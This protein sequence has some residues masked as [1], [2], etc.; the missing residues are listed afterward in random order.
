MSGIASL[1]LSLYAI[2]QFHHHQASELGLRWF[3]FFTATN[4][5]QNS[6]SQGHSCCNRASIKARFCFFFNHST[7]IYHSR[8]FKT[9]CKIRPVRILFSPLPVFLG[10]DS[11]SS[12]NFR[13]RIICL[14]KWLGKGSRKTHNFPNYPF[15]NKIK[16]WKLYNFFLN[17]LI[18]PIFSWNFSY[19]SYFF[20]IFRN[21]FNF[22]NLLKLWVLIFQ[23]QISPFPSHFHDFLSCYNKGIFRVTYI[24]S[25]I[26]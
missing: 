8:C 18:L 7:F 1:S 26:F 6:F 16:N 25:Q 14:F 21:I 24:V 22:S 23:S 9:I 20:I 13:L 10:N 12:C 4:R 5:F 3:F 2:I 19:F 11:M 17:I 15:K